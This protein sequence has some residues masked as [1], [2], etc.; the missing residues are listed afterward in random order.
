M[1][2]V[3][4]TVAAAVLSVALCS[5]AYAQ[6]ALPSNGD[7]IQEINSVGETSNDAAKKII[8]DSLGTSDENLNHL[9]SDTLD[10]TGLDEE[11]IYIEE[12]NLTVNLPGITE[13]GSIKTF[14]PE[15]G[16][17]VEISVVGSEKISEDKGAGVTKTEEGVSVS[18]VTEDMGVQVVSIL[19]EDF[20]AGYVD[21][22]VQIP[23]GFSLEKT[24]KGSINLV[25]STGEIEGTFDAPWAVD[26]EG[27]SQP[28]Y[29]EITDF[30]IRQH[31][32]TSRAVGKVAIDPD[33][34]W[35]AGTTATCAVNVAPL[36]I[37]GGAAIAARVPGLVAKI[38]NLVNRSPRIAQAV[39][40][41]GGAGE[42]AKSVIKNS[43]NNLRN[44]LPANVRDR[45]PAVNLTAQDRA[46]A[47][48]GLTFG[49][50]EVF[51]LLGI[52][53][54]VSLVRELRG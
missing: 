2:K 37:T 53:S 13:S 12:E 40:N 47:A 44:K 17:K 20:T 46:L 4:K 8:A 45:M 41:I 9:V 16:H 15:D 31:V 33:F 28:T 11:S 19:N 1:K 3:H 24:E 54:C 30:G 34:W 29:F 22:A 27:V 39:R 48:A 10:F 6:E 26:S 50:N 43:Y 25:S 42:A 14:S 32:D 52:G 23:S 7:I 36:F 18:H 38:N 49:M 5:P 21:F 35:W 51:D